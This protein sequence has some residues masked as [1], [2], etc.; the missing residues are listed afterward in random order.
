MW[1]FSRVLHTVNDLYEHHK[2]QEISVTAVCASWK[3][4]EKK[5]DS[6]I[7]STSKVK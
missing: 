5:D 1:S 6:K 4:R 7:S 2:E 3:G